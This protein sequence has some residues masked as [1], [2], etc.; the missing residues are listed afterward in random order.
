MIKTLAP[1]GGTHR[2]SVLLDYTTNNSPDTVTA[3]VI[4]TPKPE[5]A[6][7]LTFQIAGT[8]DELEAG[9]AAQLTEAVA[10][11]TAT[12]TDL[13]SLDAQLAAAKKAKEEELAAAKSK[14]TAKPAAAAA[15]PSKSKP[16]KKE[17]AKDDDEADD[18]ED[19]K[20]EAPAA[21]KYLTSSLRGSFIPVRKPTAPRMK[22]AM[23]HRRKPRERGEKC[24]RA[25]RVKT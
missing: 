15:K 18:D 19:E 25:R 16:A 17:E 8:V 5:G 4:V 9:F 7:P 13:S 24:P 6:Q 2:I 3:T 21:A 11:I 22:E 20:P 23:A 12:A 10:K 14:P 1:L